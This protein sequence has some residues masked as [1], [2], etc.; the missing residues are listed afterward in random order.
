MFFKWPNIPP[1]ALTVERAEHALR[2]NKGLPMSEILF[3]ERRKVKLKLFGTGEVVDGD[4]TQSGFT[5]YLGGFDWVTYTT[6][7]H[8]LQKFPEFLPL[9]QQV[10][11]VDA[12][13]LLA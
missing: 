4:V 11:N 9:P 6:P 5:V 2:I 13:D 10:F 12:E 1:Q 3:I 7:Q 8:L